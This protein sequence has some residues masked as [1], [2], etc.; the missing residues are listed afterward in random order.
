ME[1]YM[2]QK[3]ELSHIINNNKLI[4]LHVFHTANYELEYLLGLKPSDFEKNWFKTDIK[5]QINFN[6]FLIK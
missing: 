6:H 1:I 4:L 5:C 2:N 3:G